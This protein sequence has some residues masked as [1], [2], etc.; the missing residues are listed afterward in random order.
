MNEN[1]RNEYGQ[2]MSTG[3]NQCFVVDVVAIFGYT[4]IYAYVCIYLYIYRI[5]TRKTHYIHYKQK[6]YWIKM[7]L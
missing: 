4:A 1:E 5:V 7:R 6:K 3:A 2:M